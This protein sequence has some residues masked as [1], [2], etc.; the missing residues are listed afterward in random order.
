MGVIAARREGT[1]TD[2]AAGFDA[3]YRRER[4]G[5]CRALALSLRDVDLATEAVDEAMARAYQRWGQLSG[6]E[7]PAAWV[8]RVARNWAISRTRSRWR[9]V[10]GVPID[11]VGFHDHDPAD[12]TLAAALAGLGEEHRAVVVLRY[13]LDWS[14]E[15]VAAA[16]GVPTGT[17]KS[18]L[19]RALAALRKTMEVDRDD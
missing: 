9:S 12:E 17:V 1:V 6:Y 2:P 5:L 4:A 10:G 3:F 11:E 19:H 7:R 16:L 13:H 8:Y 14:T 18:R 15:Q